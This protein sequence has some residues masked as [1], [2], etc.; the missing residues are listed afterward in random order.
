L[1]LRPRASAARGCSAQ[2]ARQAGRRKGGGA[3][4]AAGGDN[5]DDEDDSPL[6]SEVGYG[7]QEEEGMTARLFE[8]MI[9]S[10]SLESREALAR[11]NIRSASP[12]QAAAIPLLMQ[13][14][15]VVIQSET[16]SGK[17]LAYILPALTKA[18][19]AD[20]AIESEG[21][22]SAP[23]AKVLVLVPTREL[24]VQVMADSE[25]HAEGRTAIVIEGARPNMLF[26]HQ[27]TLVVAQPEELLALMEN[28]DSD[29][30][31]ALMNSIEV[32]VVDEFD[33]LL[34]HTKPRYTGNRVFRYMDPGMF[35]LEAVLK[36]LIRQN[37]KKS[38]QM[39]AVSA[40]VH[41]DSVR[42]LNRLLRTDR[43]QRFSNAEGLSGL[44]LLRPLQKG[45]APGT[46][47]RGFAEDEVW[48]SQR[49]RQE[50]SSKSE[51][52]E[53]Q[54]EE[55]WVDQKESR[56]YSVLPRGIKHK[57][58]AVPPTGRH[59]HAIAAA[60]AKVKPAS[61]LI[62]MCP[63][64]GENVPGMVEELRN[65]G[66]TGAE[67]LS[68]VM[69]QDSSHAGRNDGNQKTTSMVSRGFR[70]ANQ[71]TRIREGT[72][73]V[74]EETPD[75]YYECPIY[76]STEESVRGLS[77]D[78]VPLVFIVGMPK[79]PEAYIHMAGRTGRLPYPKGTAVF[80]AKPRELEKVMKGYL[81]ETGIQEWDQLG[82]G[83]PAT[84][85]LKRRINKSLAKQ[86]EMK[87]KMDLQRL[88]SGLAPSTNF[89]GSSP[90]K[91][92]DNALWR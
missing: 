73:E 42:K 59:S 14:T 50:D 74:T 89:F 4:K 91:A 61:A 24:A 70:S 11:R 33:E 16:G 90:A 32:C 29:D 55:V 35:P 34:P 57:F 19:E 45:K 15:S 38:L 54:K 87:I 20:E 71:L 79:S 66:W 72:K 51:E 6:G 86:L 67:Q 40:T 26:V 21:D 17:T 25:D 84:E 78:G 46:A 88:E 77:I 60:L 5:K 31:F 68:K 8:E 36:R 30:L 12:I 69:F 82:R 3:G 64:A 85:T 27:A 52:E 44:T 23:R 58:W 37:E 7:G 2:V 41:P 92:L 39:V 22:E 48:A 62:F 76:V 80:L 81:D 9:P 28:A 10:L 56:D 53:D 75:R 63:N 65:F 43:T 83:S 49:V 1:T 47:W 18:R 13:G